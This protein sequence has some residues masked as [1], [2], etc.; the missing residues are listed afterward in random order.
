MNKLPIAK[1]VAVVSALAGE[2][3]FLLA[4]AEAVGGDA[5]A[6]LVARLA[7]VGELRSAALMAL[8]LCRMGVRACALDPHEMKLEDAF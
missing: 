1:R 8:A 2:T 4:Q 5:P 3:D 7:R 6:A